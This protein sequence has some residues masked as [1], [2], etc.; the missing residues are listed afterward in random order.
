M[1]IQIKAGFLPAAVWNV[2]RNRRMRWNGRDVSVNLGNENA[3]GPAFGIVGDERGCVTTLTVTR[4]PTG[5]LTVAIAA[6][7]TDQCGVKLRL[8]W[9]CLAVSRGMFSP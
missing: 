3:D 6:N 7:Q 2:H 4:N 9:C 1:L 5:G 8:R